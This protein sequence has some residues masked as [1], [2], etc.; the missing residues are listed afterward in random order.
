MPLQQHRTQQKGEF[1]QEGYEIGEKLD[2]GGFG[3][4]YKAQRDGRLV[5]VKVI[6][7]SHPPGLDEDLQRE[8]MILTNIR[9]EHVVQTYDI[10]RTK[11]KIY[12]FMEFAS[13]GTI[14]KFVRTHGPL[15]ETVSKL[16]F[17]PIVDALIYLKSQKI[18]HRDLKLDNVLL[19]DYMNPKL[20]DFGLSRYVLFDEKGRVRL[21]DSWVG[22]ESYMPPEMLLKKK[23][24]PFIS[25]IWSLGVCLYVMMCNVYPFDRKNRPQM[26]SNQLSRNWRWMDKV[27]R[28]VS[29]N[30]KDIENRMLEP[31]VNKR[32]S[33]EG[34]SKH[35][36]MPSSQYTATDAYH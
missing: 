28:A 34:I 21:T 1:K 25:D 33:L 19:D 6:K 13:G 30:L 31:D 35:K 11:N 36:W 5:A 9:H 17:P 16:W 8:L 10:M 27:A 4:V 20:T 26:I 2:S 18:A 3:T 14:G 15:T 22:T 32:I 24:N 7:V 29:S 12:I 23:Y